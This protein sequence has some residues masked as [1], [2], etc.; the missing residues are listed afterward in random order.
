[1]MTR[2]LRARRSLCAVSTILA[3]IGAAGAAWAQDEKGFEIYGFA[4]GDYIQDFNRVDPAW[5]DT[6][7]PSRIPTSGHPF[8]DDNQAII[9]VRQSRFGVKM[10]EPLG[11]H[12]LNVKF[13]FDF[14]G[15]GVDEGQTTIRLRHFY[16]EWGP[17]LAGQ[18]HSL[19]MDIDTFPNTIDYWGPAG[20]VF[21][22]NPQV[23]YTYALSDAAA[24][25]VAIEKPSN[26]I[27]PGNIREISPEL[28]ANLQNDEK[29]PD[30]TGQYRQDGPW[31]HVQVAAIL[32]SV[33]FETI[34]TPSNKPSDHKLG[35]GVNVSS[36]LNFFEKDV[37]HLA[38]V[39]GEGIASYMN[40]G[41]VDLA[42]SAVVPA[43]GSTPTSLSAEVV[44]LLGLL[45]YYDH[46]WSDHWSSSIG[47]SETSVDNT[48]FQAGSAFSTG[49]YASAN[50]L[51]TPTDKVLMGAE[52]L[53]GQR[54]DNDKN[55]GSDIRLQFSFK[56]SF[57][58]KDFFKTSH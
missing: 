45:I 52:V 1:M 41:G 28:G 36:N 29:L 18:T 17:I 31:G 5:D 6:L 26:D 13:E 35:W 9:S 58:S 4:Q 39:Y 51:Y 43:P 37:A 53:W 48:S 3:G 30:L 19:F 2:V 47:W 21:L 20:M 24:L 42:P 15:V 46:Y 10:S 11:D 25:A 14:F 50:I 54:E 33:G 34:G 55:H 22:R 12:E 16:G 44:P 32:R 38:V 23:R 8:G 56:Y 49:Q 40:D 7:R 27:D 57:S